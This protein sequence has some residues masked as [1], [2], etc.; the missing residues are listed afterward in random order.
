MNSLIRR[1]ELTAV[2]MGRAGDAMLWLL[3]TI[4]VLALSV[5]FMTL[6]SLAPAHAAEE[7]ISCGGVNVLAAMQSND[8]EKYKALEKQAALVPNG[9]G[10]LWR[11]EKTGQPPSFLMGTMHVTDPRVLKMPAGA[12][13]AFDAAKIVI[14]ESDEILDEK[15]VAA[16]LMSKPELTMFLDGKSI[17]DL[18]TKDNAAR[19]E[20]GLKERGI[21]L[22]AVSRMKPWMLASFVALP[23]CEFTRK[24][25][26][27][28]FLDKKIAEDAVA[29]GKQLVG[30]E[31]L[32]EQLTAMSELP[33]EFHL[34]ALIETLEIGDKMQDIMATMT[35]LYMAGDI[36]MTMPMLESQ[37]PS[38]PDESDKEGYAAF[39]KRIITDRNHVMAER[40]ATHL[41]QGGTFI[42]VGALHLPGEEG[43]VELLRKQGFTVTSVQ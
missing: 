9:K 8:P 7:A 42:A 35:D 31:T 5:L 28:S 32:V 21:P 1:E 40:A 16:S 30:L 17:T 33:M 29:A 18:L 23:A 6:L 41:A 11:V 26:G 3:A 25:Q 39:E 14:V 13:A 22:S 10:T 37:A 38:P 36:G 20:A 2:L 4:H 15:Q 43:L 34:Q 12:Q 19:L 24:A 27:A